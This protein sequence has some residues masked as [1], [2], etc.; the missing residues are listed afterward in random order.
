M[1]IHSVREYPAAGFRDFFACL[2][3]REV[4]I[5]ARY[6]LGGVFLLGA[7]LRFGLLGQHSIWFDE[8]FVAH[9]A[10]RVPWSR[11]LPLVRGTDAHPPLFYLLMKVWVGVAGATEVELRIPSA[12]FSTLSIPLTYLL[13]RRI[14]SPSAGLLAALFVAVSP[15]EIIA[16]Q[17]ARMYPLLQVLTLAC[18][19]ALIQCVEQGGARRWTLYGVVSAA[20]AY[21][22]YLGILVIAAHGLWLFWRAREHLPSWFV[23]G[24]GVLA[25]YLPWLPSLWYQTLQGHGWAWYRPPLSW[26]AL[27]DL[28]GLYAFGGSLFGM[29][30]YFSDTSLSPLDQL[31]L[32]SPFLAVFS[33]G[34]AALWKPSTRDK[35]LLESL[36]GVVVG[37]PLL[38][39]LARPM[40]YPRWFSF[41]FPLY[42]VIVAAGILRLAELWNGRRDRMVALTTAGLLLYSV[43][44]L[45]HYYIEPGSRLYDWR[46]A[47]AVVEKNARAGDFLLYT[48]Q[49]AEIAF[50][51]YFHGANPSL[52]LTP[53]EAIPG[54]ARHPTFTAAQA[55]RLASR[56]P[57]V[58]IIAT[59]PFTAAMQDRLRKDL[60]GAFQPVGQRD[61][62]DVWVTLLKARHT[63]RSSSTTPGE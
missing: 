15:L 25:V 28:G 45:A 42:A 55:E 6:C 3:T 60:E 63:S 13:G 1:T 20:M 18:T 32:L 39:S 14:L 12:V 16:G 17:E 9:I 47:A 11:V 5:P 43:P 33:L 37:A 59:P 48:N 21:T 26:Q 10:S 57:R 2:Q 36:L 23:T 38:I 53:I 31:I 50:T 52:V 58:W 4:R 19:L 8:A 27:G 56:Y 46:G 22:H 41:L 34:I 49:A 51:Y 62:G 35:G 54:P 40:F 7:V 61:F 29:G 44:V 24:V 30:D